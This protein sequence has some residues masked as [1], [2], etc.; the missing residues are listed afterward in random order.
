MTELHEIAFLKADIEKKLASG[1]A[2]QDIAIITKKNKSLE[3]I[4]KALLD[5]GI[6]VSVSKEESLFEL[7][8]IRLLVN[9]LKLLG[10][11]DEGYIHE[12]GE[13]MM[14]ILSHPAFV[15]PRL[16]LWSLSKTLY[17]A[18][19]EKTRSCVEQLRIHED[20]TLRN[21]GYFFIELTQRARY[22]RLEDIIDYI[23]GANTLRFEDEYSDEAQSGNQLQITMLDGKKK[24]YISPYFTY[25][26][27]KTQGKEGIAYAR[28]LTHLKKLI[29]T[30]RSYKKGKEFLHLKD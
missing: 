8:E 17:H 27:S 3:L 13:L 4:A 29:D 12:D 16:T 20:V 7:E 18:R 2:Y 26:F 15:I 1:V 28:H 24:N 30:I 19:G 22:E 6:P 11:L 10:N 14:E 21:I 25:F 9:L 23:T 5:A